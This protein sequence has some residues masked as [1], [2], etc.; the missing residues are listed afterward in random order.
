M[1]T[2]NRWAL[3]VKARTLKDD[4]ESVMGFVSVPL[5]FSA[6]RFIMRSIIED[7]QVTAE[8]VLFLVSVI[9]DNRGEGRRV[10]PSGH[11][12]LSCH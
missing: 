12:M 4:N 7:A 8:R 5:R 3:E 2:F 10:S 1:V 9:G 11:C 6:L